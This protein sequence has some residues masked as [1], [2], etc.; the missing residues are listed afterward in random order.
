MLRRS[1]PGVASAEQLTTTLRPFLPIEVL[2][3]SEQQNGS[4]GD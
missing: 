4:A 1:F 3:Y 2:G